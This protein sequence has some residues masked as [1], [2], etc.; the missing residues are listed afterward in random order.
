MIFKFY[1]PIKL[2][3]MTLYIK[4]TTDILNRKYNYKIEF[5]KISKDDISG[6][7]SLARKLKCPIIAQTGPSRRY[8]RGGKWYLKGKGKNY[9]ELKNDIENAY[10]NKEYPTRKLFLIKI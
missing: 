8:P 7:I 3:R 1:I 6:I 9:Y 10:E 4:Y 2:Y 5:S